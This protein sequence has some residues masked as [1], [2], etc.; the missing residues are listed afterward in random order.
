MIDYQKYIEV[1][2][3][4]IVNRDT[5]VV[6]IFLVL[7]LLLAGGFGM[8]A[9]DSG[10][11]QFTE[12][13]PAQEAFD[14]V[15]DNFERQPFESGTGT[16]T[17][18]HKSNNVL[19]KSAVLDMLR[20]QHRI[21]E[22]DSQDV[23]G[24]SSVAQAVAL[25]IDQNATT[26]PA[27]IDAVEAAPTSVVKQAAR[28]TLEER[29][30]IAGLLSNDLNR[31][32]PS[33]SATITT[34]THSV[35]GT[36]DS[37]G[38][39]GTSPLTPIQQEGVFIVGSTGADIT[40]FGSGLISAE[41]GSVISDSLILVIP[42]AVILILFFLI[43]SYRDPFDLLI[44]LICLGMAIMWTFG[45]MGWA[46]IPFTQMLIAVPPLLLA[47]GIDFGIH[48]VNRYREERVKGTEISP[49]MRITTDQLLPAFFIVT[50]TTVLGFAANGVSDLA[51]IRDF[52]L[53]AA[54]GII[55][56][57]LI[58]GIFL[59]SLK[60]FIDRK[61]DKYNLPTFSTAPIGS[62][63]SAVGRV[64]TV[65]VG[66]ARR[67]PY[68]FFVVVV[69]STAVMG[70]YGTGV[71]T[72][73]T[74]EDFLPPEDNPEYLEELP[75]SLAPSEYTVTDNINFLEDNFES[76]ESDSV[77]IYI[78]GSMQQDYAL[79]SIY[80]ANQN[81]P[82]SFVS[83]GRRAS[84]TSILGI[85]NQYEQQSPE[86]RRLVQS[87]DINNNGIPDKNLPVIYDELYASPYGDQA[88]SYLTDDYSKAR[89]V[90]SVK[91]DSSQAEI[92]E[93]TRAL[94][95]D[96]R[97]DATATGSVVV[98]KAVSD[99][100]AESAYISLALAILASAIFLVIAYWILEQR[101]SLGIANLVPILVTIAALAATM[102][103]LDIPFNVLTGTTLSIGI[104]L[105]IDYSAHL[106]HRFSEEFRGSTTLF[107]ALSVTVSGTGGALAGSMVTTTTGTGVL[108]LAITPI[109][110]QFGLLIALSVLYSFTASI[111]ILPATL[112]VW[113]E[114]RKVSP[115]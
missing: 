1:I 55:F 51:P 53:V 77:T 99:V 69:L 73:F 25:S 104:G 112:V 115:V 27:Q 11:S 50:G 87:N 94:A 68:A 56:T 80:K 91:S 33:A 43:V 52:G 92:T 98:L 72:R 78:E 103:Y 63:D 44:G 62:E 90:Y 12:G 95:D 113:D 5:T 97:F 64:L 4:W 38:T 16:T 114:A 66:I 61:R 93:D 41:L 29:P 48:A 3:D 85:I 86:F 40:V 10:T 37:A 76:S 65:G 110:G 7:T 19:S 67:A 47:V 17:L 32:E 13:V 49:S 42:A 46:G 79:E 59:P 84:A 18:I 75:A 23:V 26:L 54:V 70:A 34:V 71:D 30:S 100:I 15:N 2:D 36:S 111:V 108:V 6:G 89:I 82:D 102:R 35:E 22:D 101:P 109:L 74:T 28:Q 106:V 8:T 58:F 31:R 88:R 83:N 81:P 107:E 39:Q 96:M 60:H 21:K 14:D 105:G 57:F 24:T 9:T 20:A 45:F